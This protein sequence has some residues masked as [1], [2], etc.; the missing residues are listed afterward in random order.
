M[1]TLFN[2]LHGCL[3]FSIEAGIWQ[4][5]AAKGVKAGGKGGGGRGG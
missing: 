3:G 1:L 4:L 2:L 5:I